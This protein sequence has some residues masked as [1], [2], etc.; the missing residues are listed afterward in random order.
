[1]LVADFL[2]LVVGFYLAVLYTTPCF[3]RPHLQVVVVA[4][5]LSTPLSGG[6]MEHCPLGVAFLIR[7]MQSQFVEH[8]ARP[9]GTLFTSPR[10][11][12]VPIHQFAEEKKQMLESSS[13]AI[14]NRYKY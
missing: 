13:T 1:M 3:K 9:E 7:H 6:A 8:V 14:A 4:V 11:W 10:Q 5:V 2:L 12:G